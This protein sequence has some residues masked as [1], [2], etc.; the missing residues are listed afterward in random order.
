MQFNL[1]VLLY[2]LAH[3]LCKFA[4][5]RRKNIGNK[6]PEILDVTVRV[7]LPQTTKHRQLI[8]VLTDKDTA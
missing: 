5:I 6:H 2:L 3:Q 4:Y 7:G 8:D 1:F